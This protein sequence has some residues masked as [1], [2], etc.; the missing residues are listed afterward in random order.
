MNYYTHW[1][2]PPNESHNNLVS[3]ESRN[4]TWSLFSTSAL[5]HFPNAL[6]DRLIDL[7]SSNV[8]PSLPIKTQIM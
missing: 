8:C 5:I 1:I 3:F 4:G 2:L 6:K 7:D